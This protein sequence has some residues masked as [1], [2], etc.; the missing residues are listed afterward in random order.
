MTFGN[1][2]IN[3][4]DFQNLIKQQ[5]QHNQ[6]K[7]LFYELKNEQL[8]LSPS[9]LTFNVL[10]RKANDISDFIQT[11]YKDDTLRH[12]INY[13]ADKTM[14]LFISVNQFLNFSTQ[15]HYELRKIYTN[16]VEK[17]CM[18]VNKKETYPQD[19]EQ[20]LNSHYKSL[21]RFLL[22]SNGNEIFKKYRNSP[23]LP[24]I[25]CAEYTSEFQ[26]KLLGIN[27]STIKEP[28]LDVG[29]GKQASFVTFLKD[30][31]IEAYGLDRGVQSISG[32]SQVD[33]LDYN[34]LPDTWGTIISHMAFS[35]HFMHNHL[36]QD[37]DYETYAEKYM[38]I[39]RSLKIGGSFIYAP[40]LPFIEEVLS[41][42]NIGYIV[43]ATPNVT[44]IT[45]IT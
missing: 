5:L 11:A 32:V 30:H 8:I 37:G 7:S 40:S 38:E 41:K 29:C 22:E 44:K 6:N 23:D 14:N 35:N 15:K 19:V 42:A 16:L 17:V 10:I 39:V 3:L 25:K 36:R 33:W 34:F 21:Q 9:N 12:L 45:R 28:L 20:L 13:M 24:E 18:I 1:T 4:M 26:M 2:G 31:R 43:N 27:L